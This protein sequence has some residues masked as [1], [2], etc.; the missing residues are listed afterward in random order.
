MN[1]CHIPKDI[2][3][4]ILKNLPLNQ[5]INV[6]LVNKCFNVVVKEKFRHFWYRK[7]LGLITK[8][9][10]Y[11]QKCGIPLKKIHHHHIHI[12]E[13][14]LRIL[15]FKCYYKLTRDFYISY[16]VQWEQV[17]SNFIN[18]H[19]EEFNQYVVEAEK[20]RERV[21]KDGPIIGYKTRT[22]YFPDDKGDL[23]EI[24]V[25]PSKYNMTSNFEH[26]YALTKI[27][28]KS[29]KLICN[30]NHLV[31]DLPCSDDDYEWFNTHKSIY[32]DRKCY[33]SFYLIYRYL[34]SRE[35]GDAYEYKRMDNGKK[36]KVMTD[37]FKNSPFYK[38]I[39]AE[40]R[41]I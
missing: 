35:D 6:R 40:Y 31:W 19:K 36:H 20:I 21:F 32:N 3:A 38:K 14:N 27:L 16:D 17:E 41:C 2:I 4:I 8:N 30:R 7:Y 5:L 18:D 13:L 26:L 39:L 34:I 10:R 29:Y 12:K 22:D 1:I 28:R 25:T 24:K 11:V 15:D 23:H 33:M 37:K 9:S